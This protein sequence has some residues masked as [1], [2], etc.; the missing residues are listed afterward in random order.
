M[1]WGNHAAFRWVKRRC[2]NR[3]ADG[4]AARK[5]LMV[6]ASVYD[7]SGRLVGD[8]T[9][10]GAVY[11]A[12][13]H[14]VGQ[15]TGIGSI[16]S[17]GDL[18][19]AS[20]RHVGHA[21]GMNSI[22]VTADIYDRQ[23]N[24]VGKVVGLRSISGS[25]YI[26]NRSGST[27]G[28]VSTAHASAVG[29]ALLLLPLIPGGATKPVHDRGDA[30]GSGRA[31]PE[32]SI[33]RPPVVYPPPRPRRRGR[34][35]LIAFAALLVAGGMTAAAVVLLNRPGPVGISNYVAVS[36]D[37]KLIAAAEGDSV[38]LWDASAR[39]LT[40]TLP[41][42]QPSASGG[43]NAFA[44]SPDGLLLAMAYSDGP[45]LLWSTSARR[46]I[47]A[48][49]AATGA[50][51]L[52]FSPDGKTLAVCENDILL[53]SVAHERVTATLHVVRNSDAGSPAAAAFSP[54]G[55][56]LAISIYAS[57]DQNGKYL[58]PG[59]ELWDL[60]TRHVTGNL[61]G[62]SG[63]G[64]IA[65]SRNGHLL[66]AAEGFS[67]SFSLWDVT[68]RPK[69]RTTLTDPR[70]SAQTYSSIGIDPVAFS[71]DGTTLIT[72]DGSPNDSTYIWDVATGQLRAT[73]TDPGSLGVADAAVTPDG[74][75]LIAA[76]G[77]GSLYVWQ[78]SSGAVIATLTR[79]G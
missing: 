51:C 6:M 37:G 10:D 32:R 41:D 20:G 19:D 12:R 61:A 73:L 31:I 65:Y 22:S 47:A 78:L 56:T 1:P 77:D 46:V 18:E 57:T 63:G 66:V 3:H 70:P 40:A 27:V 23:H 68:G 34:R 44:L 5:E 28:E 79:P 33:P 43:V 29:A 7:H 39:H 69:L 26:E 21:E 67:G 59:I 45:T 38:Y 48:I 13:Q 50:G 15:V 9:A 35:A 2:R 4:L 64:D 72:A 53:W 30:G 42:P 24:Y 25:C 8:V 49:P 58:A 62:G 55:R 71:P 74:M 60:R 76:D 11:D 36:P 16:S 14:R 54:D 17:G 52:A 75:E